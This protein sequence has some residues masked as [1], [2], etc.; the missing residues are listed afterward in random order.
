MLLNIFTQ[1]NVQIVST[2]WL[3]SLEIKHHQVLYTWIDIGVIVPNTEELWL[4]IFYARAC[5]WL[6]PCIEGD[7]LKWEPWNFWDIN[8][9]WFK[10]IRVWQVQALFCVFVY[11]LFFSNILRNVLGLPLPQLVVNNLPH[12]GFRLL[13]TLNLFILEPQKSVKRYLCIF[14][15]FVKLLVLIIL[16]NHRLKAFQI[17]VEAV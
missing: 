1:W 11:Y 16:L 17:F 12:L 9:G 7:G 3:D 10:F 6:R 8:I 2:C 14:K 13:Q 15:Y 5:Y 4:F